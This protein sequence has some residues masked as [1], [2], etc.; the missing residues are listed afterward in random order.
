M[1][2]CA[3]ARQRVVAR[4]KNIETILLGGREKRNEER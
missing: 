2:A 3:T 4:L 1:R